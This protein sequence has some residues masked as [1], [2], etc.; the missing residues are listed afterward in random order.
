MRVRDNAA[1]AS[2][3]LTEVDLQELDAAF[4]RPDGAPPLE[5]L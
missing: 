2:V 1:A 5:I 4:P 3:N